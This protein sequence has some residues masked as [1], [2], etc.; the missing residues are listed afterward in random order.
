[1]KIKWGMFI[2]DGAGK[3]GGNVMSANRSGNYVR[4]RITPVNPQSPVSQSR[5]AYFSQ[6]TQL[7]KGLSAIN[8]GLWNAATINYP[9][10][11]RIGNTYYP[12]GF[13]LFIELNLNC[14]IGGF[15]YLS[16][17]PV[18]L[19]PI[20]PTFSS[21]TV[22]FVATSVDLIFA[23]ALP[24][25]TDIVIAFA[26]PA[27]SAGKSM[28]TSAYRFIQAFANAA[29]GSQN[30]Y[31]NY[32]NIFPAGEIGQKVF[33]KCFNVN[34]AGSQSVPVLQSAIVT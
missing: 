13:N 3:S 9:R 22:D 7:W 4:Q 12:S 18:K 10:L 14:L 1:M 26:S 2:T 30:I 16:A 24:V 27:V 25:S 23:P 29:Q 6:L 15:A 5:R 8:I 21:L 28:I 31:A 20:T 19:I 33:V 11:D 17:P 34:G 32:H